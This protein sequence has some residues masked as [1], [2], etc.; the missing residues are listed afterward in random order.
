MNAAQDPLRLLS[1]GTGAIPTVTGTCDGAWG[2]A[3]VRRAAETVYST[4][5]ARPLWG[6]VQPNG[7]Q[8]GCSVVALNDDS[9]PYP[10]GTPVN[11]YVVSGSSI[12][13]LGLKGELVM[14]NGDRNPVRLNPMAAGTTVAVSATSGL[15]VSVVGGSPVPSSNSATLVGIRYE[16]ATGT[17]SGTVNLQV[18]SPSQLTTTFSFNLS[19]SPS[20]S[21]C[22]L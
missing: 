10:D 11:Y 21:S 14:I 18:T 20:V 13:G 19:T 12:A 7:L 2:R 1:L 8:S 6:T 15:T 16:F 5:T 4:S 9:S 3:Y 22:T 17:N